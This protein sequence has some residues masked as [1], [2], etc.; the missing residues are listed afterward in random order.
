MKLTAVVLTG[1]FNFYFMLEALAI[2]FIIRIIKGV[3]K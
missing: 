2:I 3:Y 1:F